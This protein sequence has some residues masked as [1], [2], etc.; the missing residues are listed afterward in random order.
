[1]CLVDEVKSEFVGVSKSTTSQDT[2]S[3]HMFLI[4]IAARNIE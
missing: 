2:K 1:M 4:Y 3:E